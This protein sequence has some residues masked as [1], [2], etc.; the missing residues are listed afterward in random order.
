MAIINKI[1]NAK[2]NTAAF[3]SNFMVEKSNFSPKVLYVKGK[4]NFF[5]LCRS[6]SAPSFGSTPVGV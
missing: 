1:R 2:S 4:H 3:H 5:T 6:R